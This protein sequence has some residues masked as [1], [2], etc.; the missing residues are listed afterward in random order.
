MVS[1]PLNY[2][3]P[4][5]LAAISGVQARCR[6]WP[7]A[8]AH[9]LGCHFRSSGLHKFEIQ[10][11]CAKIWLQPYECKAL[12]AKIC[13]HKF[14]FKKLSANIWLQTFKSNNMFAQIWLQ[15]CG[16]KHL[17]AFNVCKNSVSNWCLRHLLWKW[18]SCPYHDLCHRSHIKIARTHCLGSMLANNVTP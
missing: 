2:S 16:C 9:G 1:L 6:P 14:D 4:K 11:L 8:N 18:T 12:T 17:V 15:Y 3:C 10:N 5:E 13:L 7:P